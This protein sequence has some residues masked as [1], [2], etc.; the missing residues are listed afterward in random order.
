MKP[1]LIEKKILKKLLRKAYN[2]T[3]AEYYKDKTFTHLFRTIK[4]SWYYIL[5]ILFIVFIFVQFYIHNKELKLKEKMEQQELKR[6]N[7]EMKEARIKELQEETLKYEKE[8]FNSTQYY[9]NN[10]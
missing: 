8:S 3:D 4:S 6:I 10:I 7:R 5:I 1:E 9:P 2:Q